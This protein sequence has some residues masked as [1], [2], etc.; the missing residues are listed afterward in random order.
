MPPKE[1][2]RGG[3]QWGTGAP[4]VIQ[5]AWTLIDADLKND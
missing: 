5:E 1:H 4:P 3:F 2:H